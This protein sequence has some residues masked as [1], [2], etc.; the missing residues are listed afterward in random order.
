MPR[1]AANLTMLYNEHAFLDRFAAAAADGFKGVE[2]LFPYE[3]PAADIAKRLQD[4]GLQQVLFNA[5]PGDWAAGER[6]L[7]CLPGREAEF[8]NGIDRALD[9]AAA[10]D[11]PRIHVM[12]GLVPAGQAREALRLLYLD[13]L[14]WAAEQAQQVGRC[15]LIEPINQRDMPGYFLSRQDEAHALVQAVGAPNLQVQFDLYHCQVTEGD[16]AMKIRQYLPTG[17]VGHFQIAGV[18]E[19]HEPDRGELHHPYLFSVID[20]VAAQCGWQGWVGCEYRPWR[21]AVPGG[22]S[23]GLG[24]M[25]AFR[26]KAARI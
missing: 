21:G 3:H 7:A 6:G 11:C 19:R 1:F 12:A 9:Y 22:T 24:W 8:R 16:V 13:N 15:V 26:N 20:E 10:L 18:P 23:T 25:D 4:H 14:R 5:P 2:Y 17:R